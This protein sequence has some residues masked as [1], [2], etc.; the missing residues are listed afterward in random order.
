MG[1]N[2]SGECDAKGCRVTLDDSDDIFCI[3]CYA[4][5]ETRIAE[6][7]AEAYSLNAHIEELEGEE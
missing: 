5:L 3:G 6:L 1:F 2:L 4:E 7:E